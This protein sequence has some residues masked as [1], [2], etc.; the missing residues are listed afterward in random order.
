MT[1]KCVTVRKN[2]SALSLWALFVIAPTN[3]EDVAIHGVPNGTHRPIS[4]AMTC[5]RVITRKPFITACIITCAK[6]T[7]TVQWHGSGGGAALSC[8]EVATLNLE[9]YDS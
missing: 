7:A 2:E 3:R 6:F 8:C 1:V 4:I 9:R 5:V